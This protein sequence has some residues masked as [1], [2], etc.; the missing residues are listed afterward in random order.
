M[1]ATDS[2]IANTYYTV[3]DGAKQTGNSVVLSEEGVHTLVYWSLDKAGNVEAAQL[4]EVKIDLMA[5]VV[6][7]SGAASYTIDQTVT[8][9]C[10]ATD[11]IASVYGTPC[12]KPLLQAKAYTLLSG[13]NTVYVTAEDVAGHKTT[14]THTFTLRLRQRL[15]A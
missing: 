8:M 2:G 13:Q 1:K 5:P 9:T 14:A 4:L 15:T 10:S 3:D 12:A 7:I 11:V 6:Q